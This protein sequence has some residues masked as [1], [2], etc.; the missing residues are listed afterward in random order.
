ML[1]HTIDA[2]HRQAE[3]QERDARDVDARLSRLGVPADWLGRSRGYTELRNPYAGKH[4]NLTVRAVLEQKDRSLAHWLAQRAGTTISGVDYR[5]EE[6]A[7]RRAESAAR[8]QQMTE[9]LRAK[10]QAV[11]QR[12]EFERT[13]GRWVNGRLVR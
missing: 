1:D 6:A 2:A 9:A 7:Q 12:H 10:N 4:S 5:A 13:H 11:L 3:A 8:L